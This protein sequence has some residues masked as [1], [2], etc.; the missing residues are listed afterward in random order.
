MRMA[1]GMLTHK[2]KSGQSTPAFQSQQATPSESQSVASQSAQTIQS[3]GNLAVQRL[4]CNGPLQAKLAISQP[5]DPDEQEADWTADRIMRMQEPAH[6]TAASPAIQRNCAACDSNKTTCPKCEGE[7]KVQRKEISRPSSETGHSVHS[8]TAVPR[9]GGRPLPPD[10][11]ALFEPRFGRDFSR[12]RV[13]TGSWATESAHAIK[14]RAFTLGRDVVFGEEEYLPGSLEGQ[15]LLA[16]ELTHVVQ[17]GHAAALPA[18]GPSSSMQPRNVSDGGLAHSTERIAR[19]SDGGADAG[20]PSTEPK[21]AGTTGGSPDQPGGANYSRQAACVARRGGCITE[22]AAGAVVEPAEAAQY[23]KDCRELEH[24]SY[25]GPDIKPSDE[26][27]R[28]YTSGQLVDP[29]KLA[30]LQL[31]T[32]QYLARLTAGELT[33]ADAQRIDSALRLAH[34]ALQRGGMSLPELPAAAIPP[35]DMSPDG[36]AV[37]LAGLP[38]LALPAETAA[39]TAGGAAAAAGPTLT[40]IEGGAVAGGATE[41]GAVGAT[42]A[43]GTAAATVGVVL[44]GAAVLVGVGLVIY[45]I[46]TLEDPKV[47]PTIPK[48]IDEASDT[49]Q[50]TLAT[51]KPPTA[52]AAQKKPV[53]PLGLSKSDQALWEKCSALHDTYKDTQ[54]QLGSSVDNDVINR[55]REK[56]YNNRA[57]PQEIIDL[58]ALI[59]KQIPIVERFHRERSDYVKAGCDKFDWFNAGTT[60]ADRLKR[61]KGELEHVSSQLRNLRK[62]RKDLKCI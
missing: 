36:P 62:L 60:E 24:T 9:D 46:L 26:E 2:V 27:C 58:C 15:R 23:N 56:F 4:F 22:R 10:M 49:I 19:Q 33:L 1:A 42:V 61:H 54:E 34:T 50:D 35:P 53:M 31:L 17:Q 8:E 48:A 16:H 52:Q 28:Q 7:E 38:A 6:I 51:A 30:R 3:A 43:G 37:L 39:G 44:I 12:V 13:H 11:R 14:A 57:T 5:N 25:A 45:F 21:D 59:D 55:L 32:M 40:L 47:D 41:V 20:V 18:G 29:A